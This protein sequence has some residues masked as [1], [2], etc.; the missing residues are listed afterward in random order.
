MEQLLFGN[1]DVSPEGVAALTAQL[2]LFGPEA[3]PLRAARPSLELPDMDRD[4]PANDSMEMA[5]MKCSAF[6]DTP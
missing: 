6:L 1:A 4:M 5:Q 2:G 3:G